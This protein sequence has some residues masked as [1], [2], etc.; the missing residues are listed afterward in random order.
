MH[1]PLQLVSPGPQ[2]QTP[3]VQACPAAQTLPQ[4]PQLYV[5]LIVSKQDEP[6]AVSFAAHPAPQAPR[7]QN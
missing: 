4:G 6:Q 2:P 1:C 5:S 3:A 7:L